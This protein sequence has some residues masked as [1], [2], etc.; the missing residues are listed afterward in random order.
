LFSAIPDGDSGALAQIFIV[1]SLVHIRKPAPSA[2]VID[3]DQ[4]KI[5]AA[6]FNNAKQ[7][8]QPAPPLNRRAAPAFISEGSNNANV[9]GGCIKRNGSRLIGDRVLLM[10]ST[11]SEVLGCTQQTRGR[12]VGN[13]AWH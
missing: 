3:Q 4:L 8:L 11:H 7:L 1:R 10:L 9:V 6:G 13:L 2:H 5:S 12:R